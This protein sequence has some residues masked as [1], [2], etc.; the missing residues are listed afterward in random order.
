MKITII[1]YDNWGLNNNLKNALEQNGHIVHHIN[2]FDFKHNY[3]NFQTKLYNFILKTIFSKNIKNIYYGKEILK[4]LEKNNEI[5]DI[6]LTIKGDFIDPKSILE[7][8][9]FT[10]KSI[11]F[12]NDSITRCP[13]IKHTIPNFDEVYSFEKDDCEKYNLKFLTN[14]IYPI[15]KSEQKKT[16]YQVFNISSKDR[17]FSLILKIVSILKEKNINYK[18]IVFDKKNKNQKSN[19]EYISKQIPLTEVNDY[20]HTSQVLLDINRKGQKGLTFRVFESIGLQKKLI[21]TNADIKNYDFY[22][23][24]NILIIDEKKPNISLDFFNT[25]Y[26]KISKEMLKNYTIKGWI[27]QVLN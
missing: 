25:K 26:E 4:K 14:W 10:Q 12:F 19:I 17:R 2:F 15:P 20:L 9:K 7:F 24:N 11:A 21:T 8:K 23:P 5:Q 3:P 16:N 13:K 18:I 6:I 22:N 27:N 1:S